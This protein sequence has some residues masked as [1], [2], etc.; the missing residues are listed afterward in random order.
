MQ[1]V[2]A[3]ILNCQKL[4]TVEICHHVD[5]ALLSHLGKCHSCVVNHSLVNKVN[6][7]TMLWLEDCWNGIGIANAFEHVR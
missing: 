4:L 6:V 1:T 2:Q 3:D 5:I 7:V